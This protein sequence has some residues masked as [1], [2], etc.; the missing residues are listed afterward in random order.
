MI[1]ILLVCMNATFGFYVY[2]RCCPR[3][4][5]MIAMREDEYA[6]FEDAVPP[7]KM[8]NP[9]GRRIALLTYASASASLL[10]ISELYRNL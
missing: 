3:E 2:I 6:R 10:L 1:L 4:E 5:V 7:M 9:L 8:L